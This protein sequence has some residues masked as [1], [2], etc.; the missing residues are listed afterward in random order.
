MNS[1]EDPLGQKLGAVAVPGSDNRITIAELR[2]W[3][4]EYLRDWDEEVGRFP[5]LATDLH[6]NLWMADY[7]LDKDA[8]WVAIVFRPAG[9]DLACGT[10]N[11]Y[12][13]R[14]FVESDS[15]QDADGIF[16][17]LTKRFSD[18]YQTEAITRA[19]AES[20]LGRS[21][22]PDAAP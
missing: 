5:E 6:W 2:E 4:L 22:P 18:N 16:P 21:F 17:E 19:L 14:R 8:M 11:G 13:V 3:V 10:G 7:D 9:I 1:I 12:S 20:W 15:P